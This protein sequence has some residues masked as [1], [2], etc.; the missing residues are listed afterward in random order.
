[1][2]KIGHNE[3]ITLYQV[4]DKKVL[5]ELGITGQQS[6]LGKVTIQIITNGVTKILLVKDEIQED[7]K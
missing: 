7:E 1:M 3:T 2:D 6:K 5:K 4:I